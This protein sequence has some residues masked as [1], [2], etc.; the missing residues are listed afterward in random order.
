M[1]V[2]FEASWWVAVLFFAAGWWLSKKLIAFGLKQ[3][4]R[5]RKTI[6]VLLKKLEWDTLTILRT[7]VDAELHERAERKAP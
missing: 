2:D 3:S 7:E 6:R 1:A 4:T 5:S